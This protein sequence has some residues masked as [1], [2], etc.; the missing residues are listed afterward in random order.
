ME[1]SKLAVRVRRVEADDVVTRGRMAYESFATFNA[2]IGLPAGIDWDSAESATASIKYLS[3]TPSIHGVIA[4]DNTSGA[5][6]GAAF[7]H[8]CP[9]AVVLTTVY[10]L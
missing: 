2:S 7:I 6:M 5:L 9:L 8:P 10:R 4:V 3:T 1:A